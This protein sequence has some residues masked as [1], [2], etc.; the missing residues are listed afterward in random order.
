MI[1]HKKLAL[2]HILKK[3]LGLTEE[4][5]RLI[6]HKSAGVETA[7]DLTEASF[8]KLMNDFVRSRHYKV[9]TNGLTLRQKMFIQALV[10]DLSWDENHLRN[11]MHK[12]YH[13]NEI[14]DL[15][16]KEAIKVIEALK[17]IRQHQQPN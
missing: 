17:N 6:L 12:Y 13:K 14:N 10:K 7:K 1:D 15:T 16:K 8:R 9:N 3:E 2:I 5:Y 4:E 11:F